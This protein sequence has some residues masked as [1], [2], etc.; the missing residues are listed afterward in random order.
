MSKALLNNV[1]YYKKRDSSLDQN[2]FKS[3]KGQAQGVK[4]PNLAKQTRYVKSKANL[5]E[6]VPQKKKAHSRLPSYDGRAPATLKPLVGDP[7]ERARRNLVQEYGPAVDAYLKRLERSCAIS[8]DHLA[9]HK[10]NGV[11]RAKMVDWMTE[12]M[13]A[14]KCA[15]QTYF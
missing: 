15:D 10:I 9:G 4:L 7:K 6:A 12:V 2:N 5:L 11:Y 14:F 1:K 3:N 8:A 13:T